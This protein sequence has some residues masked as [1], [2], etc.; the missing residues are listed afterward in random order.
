MR[1][2]RFRLRPEHD[3][4]VYCPYICNR[5]AFAEMLRYTG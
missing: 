5:M 3:A 2:G 1:E 4:Q